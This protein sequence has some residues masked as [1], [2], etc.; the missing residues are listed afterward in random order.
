MLMEEQPPDLQEIRAILSDIRQDDQR[1]ASVI[2]RMR[3]LLKR[4]S[5]ERTQLSMEQLLREV[6]AL[7][8]FN[9]A[10]GHTQLSLNV[11]PDLP[12][13]YGD[14]VQLQQVLLNLV[15]NGIAAM[16]Q[17]PPEKRLLIVQARKT[18]GKMVT[19]SVLD[20]GPG[21]PGQSFARVFEPFYSTKPEGMGMG[22]AVS[23]T[24]IEAH[25]GKIWA[26]NHPGG[27]A[28]FS[29]TVPTCEGNQ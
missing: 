7:T 6:A 2:D 27:G 8:R 23:K 14:R 22:L 11:P 28:C 18:D 20:S 4:R 26:E 16:V 12:P 19:V 3:A 9:V 5:V 1:A 13:I 29:F 24:I 21:V 17:Q 15:V 10:Q 25:Q